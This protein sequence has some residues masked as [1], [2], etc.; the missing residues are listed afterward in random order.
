MRKLIFCFILIS[1]AFC[2][3]GQLKNGYEI[4]VN[5]RELQDS[6]VFLAYHLGD[7]Q[8]L[9]DTLKLDPDGHGVFRGTESLPQGIYMVV[10]PGRR[11]F[12]ILI[13]SE[14]F[15]SLSCNYSDYFK[16]LE[17][18]GSEENTRFVD[19]QKKWVAMQDDAAKLNERIQKN[20]QGT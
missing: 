1:S 17:F 2:S 13:S 4:K 9:K 15:F 19:Y 18:K 16:S 3:T 20:K 14:Q 6:T 12:E 8:Y 10:L 5:I 7:K 11:Y